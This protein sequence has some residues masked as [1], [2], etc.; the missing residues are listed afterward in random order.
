QNPAISST[1]NGVGDNTITLTAT[2]G[3]GNMTP[4]T[5][6]LT[7]VDNIPP[8]IIC[9]SNQSRNLDA[10]CEYVLED[11]TSL[12]MAEDNC[13]SVTVTQSPMENTI[14]TA[15]SNTITLTV[16]DAAGLTANCDF[17]LF[18]E[19]NTPPTAVCQDITVYL[20]G[21]GSATI[22]AADIDG[23]SSDNCDTP[24]L[25][26]DITTFDCSNVGNPVT[27]TLAAIDGSE[28]EGTCEATVTVQ[29]TV[30]PV[31][32]CQNI[33]VF[34]STSGNATITAADVDGGSSDNC[35]VASLSTSPSAF[36]CADVGSQTTTLTVTD[37]NSNSK[38][39]TSTIMVMDTNTVVTP[40]MMVPLPAIDCVISDTTIAVTIE[41]EAGAEAE[42]DSNGG[43]TFAFASVAC[44][45]NAPDLASIALT[46]D[47]DTVFQEPEAGTFLGQAGLDTTILVIAENAAGRDTCEVMVSLIDTTPPAFA[48]A[49]LPDTFYLDSMGMVN[50]DE[51]IALSA[52]AWADCSNVDVSAFMPEDF[53]CGDVSEA[54]FSITATD[55]FGNATSLEYMVTVLDTIAPE[56]THP[57]TT[58]YLDENGL[59][60][61]RVEEMT[62]DTVENCMVVDVQL[63]REEEEVLLDFTGAGANDESKALAVE[64][65]FDC[66]DI[67]T[68]AE[69]SVISTDA[70]GNM[71]TTSF[72]AT[73]L[74]TLAPIITCVSDTVYL[75]ETGEVSDAPGE[76]VT[77]VEDNCPPGLIIG[78]P[79]QIFTCVQVGVNTFTETRTDDS[80]N[81]SEPCTF[82][83]TVLDTIAPTLICRDT[84]LALDEAGMATALVP[85]DLVVTLEDNCDIASMSMEDLEFVCADVGPN[86]RTLTAIDVNGNQAQ[87]FP[88]IT[89]IDTL[90][91]T[92]ICRDTTLA[93]DEAGMATAIVPEDLVITLEDNCGIA[94]MSMDDFDFDCED[95]GANVRTLTAIDVNGNQAQCFPTIT[96]I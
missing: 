65:V 11:L 18:A 62:F 30:S 59:A 71:D 75:D 25:D 55:D 37:V 44:N 84:T 63:E 14:L 53:N 80:G 68:P 73:V 7:L 9:P 4:C 13:N 89:I 61:L 10:T 81:E 74:D 48:F 28:E 66:N 94:S 26:A 15:T 82:T 23:G 56:V 8:T 90:A 57:D 52:Q 1:I 92:L 51:A 22:T 96:I 43:S 38:S 70:S 67:G 20:D 46:T 21:A 88:T 33:S 42:G 49:F 40:C 50:I 41:A 5:F 91:P 3:A 69:I 45:S 54:M 36:T 32:I 34:L 87:C 47:A 19:D 27:V 85:E 31:A 6:T 64:I 24:D 2:D 77:I 95:V 35:A 39:C 72:I 58:L 86:V 83:V 17:T 60:V 93:L 16:T 79:L 76:N 29:D 12:A 78:S